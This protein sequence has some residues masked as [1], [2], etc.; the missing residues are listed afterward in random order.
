MM[1]SIFKDG[2]PSL[3]QVASSVVY[4]NGLHRELPLRRSVA[5]GGGRPQGLN[6]APSFWSIQG[7]SNALYS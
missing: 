2:E 4:L 5:S 3:V 6:A 7:S 1:L